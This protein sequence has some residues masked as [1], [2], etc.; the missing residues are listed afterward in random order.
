MEA[1]RTGQPAAL[2]QLERYTLHFHKAESDLAE[3]G[4]HRCLQPPL[5]PLALIPGCTTE[6]HSAGPERAA[7]AELPEAP[8]AHGLL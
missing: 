2:G 1:N 6:E 5:A 8:N 3:L 7:P 4:E